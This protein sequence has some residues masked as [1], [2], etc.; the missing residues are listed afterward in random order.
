[1]TPAGFQL[2]ITLL[3]TVN[4]MP[5]N[6]LKELNLADGRYVLKK[7]ISEIFSYSNVNSI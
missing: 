2:Q 3:M 5:S 7:D 6:Y 4:S 1:M